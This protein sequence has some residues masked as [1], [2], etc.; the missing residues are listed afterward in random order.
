MK[1]HIIAVLFS[2]LFASVAFS[3]EPTPTVLA[4]TTKNGVTT[5][6][7]AGRVQADIKINTDGSVTVTAFPKVKRVDSGGETIGDEVLDTAA[8]FTADLPAELAAKVIAVI[9]A[10]YLVKIAPVTA[11]A[12]TPEP[13]PGT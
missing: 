12:P 3:A 1:K 2:A 11:P 13:A 10:A 6:T 8:A 4:S 9:K 7:T 5:L